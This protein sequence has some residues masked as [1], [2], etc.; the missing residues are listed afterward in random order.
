MTTT[1]CNS[2]SVKLRAGS[3]IST[4]I[5]DDQFTELINDA[6]DTLNVSA[7]NVDYDLIA[8]YSTLSD[9]VK[10]ILRQGTAALAAVGA[11]NFDTDNYGSL[12]SAT[13]NMNVN[14]TIFK[15]AESKIKEKQNT[16]WMKSI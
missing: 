2:G 1:F 13:T 5:T 15:D 8:K 16:D 7:K 9:N 6:E 4:D 11:T 14:W 10:L 3:N 12:A